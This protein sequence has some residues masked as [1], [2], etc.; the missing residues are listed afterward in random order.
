MGGFEVKRE[1]SF[2]EVG[3]GG[4]REEGRVT[5]GGAFLGRWRGWSLQGGGTRYI[6]VGGWEAEGSEEGRGLL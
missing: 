4:S 3:R 5:G 1:P 2:S 6:H